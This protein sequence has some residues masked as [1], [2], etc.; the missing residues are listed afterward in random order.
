MPKVNNITISLTNSKLGGKIPSV[1]LPPSRP[2]DLAL[3][4]PGSAMLA[5]AIGAMAMW[6]PAGKTII[7][8]I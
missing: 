1:N 5:K 4:A 2:V 8:S 7:R 6:K 3:H